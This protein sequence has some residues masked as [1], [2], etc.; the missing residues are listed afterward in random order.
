MFRID[1]LARL[2]VGPSGYSDP[3]AFWFELEDLAEIFFDDQCYRN[4]IIPIAEFLQ[5]RV[6][7]GWDITDGDDL[8]V[9]LGKY[10]SVRPKVRGLKK[11]LPFGA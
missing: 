9:E 7:D 8:E 1:E 4:A 3:E 6:L 2:I 10:V 5:Q 11:F